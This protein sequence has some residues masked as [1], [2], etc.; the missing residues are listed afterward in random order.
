MILGTNVT[1]LTVLGKPLTPSMGFTALT[2][3][4]LLRFPLDY[5][6]DMLNFLVRTRVSLRRIESFLRTPDVKGIKDSENTNTTNGDGSG[7]SHG[8]N[9]NRGYLH[10]ELSRQAYTDNVFAPKSYQPYTRAR[11]SNVPEDTNT[12]PSLPNT[13]G[14]IELKNL[15][16]AWAPTLKEEE[17]KYTKHTKTD[18]T[19]CCA[20]RV[21]HTPS[22]TTS[23]TT[24]T[25]TSSTVSALHHHTTSAQ[26]DTLN[27]AEDDEDGDFSAR[28]ANLLQQLAQRAQAGH[29]SH[30][31]AYSAI[32]SSEHGIMMTDADTW[33]DN[34]NNQHTAKDLAPTVILENTTFSIPRGALAVVVGVTGSGK[35]SLLQGA[36][37]GKFIYG[38]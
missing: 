15:T 3:F 10:T 20:R 6:P 17:E 16:L 21:N 1:L 24:S 27:S 8:N 35:S 23:N 18:F 5:F 38:Y 9:G 30:N 4:N 26:Y 11:D 36:L 31:A 32:D 25:T 7:A 34:N 37:L 22:T 28:E 12:I 14:C 2:L 19:L 13:V 33:E 29:S